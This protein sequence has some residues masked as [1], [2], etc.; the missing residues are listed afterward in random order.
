[1]LEENYTVEE[2]VNIAKKIK[3]IDI[4]IVEEEMNKLIKIGSNANMISERS[5]IGNNVV[6]YFTFL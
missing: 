5:K 4:E 1:M 6:D 2:K 3:D